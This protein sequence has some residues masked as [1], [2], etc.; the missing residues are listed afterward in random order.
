[1][2]NKWWSLWWPSGRWKT[3]RQEKPR[4][5]LAMSFVK[6]RSTAE[7]QRGEWHSHLLLMELAYKW[8][9]CRVLVAWEGFLSRFSGSSPLLPLKKPDAFSLVVLLPSFTEHELSITHSGYLLPREVKVMRLECICFFFSLYKT[10]LLLLAVGH[11]FLSFSDLIS[12]DNRHHCII[13]AAL[14]TRGHHWF[15]SMS[16]IRKAE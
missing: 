7:D 14:T 13:Y 4:P 15:L 11:F 2:S 1:M 16:Q 12:P 5:S 8:S 3:F 10:P 6:F 9:G